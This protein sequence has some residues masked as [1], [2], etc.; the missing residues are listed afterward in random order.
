MSDQKIPVL[1]V[2]ATGMLG[3]AVHRQ[4]SKSDQIEL[5]LTVRDQ[6]QNVAVNFADDRNIC[7]FD[8]LEDD[9]NEMIEASKHDPMVGGYIVNCIGII[10]PHIA[11]NVG[12]A[13]YINSVLP[14]KLAELATAAQA[15]LIHISTDCVYSGQR[16]DYDELDSHDEQDVYGRSK[17]LGEPVNDAMVIRTSIIGPEVHNNS[18]LIAWVL[19]EAATG[20]KSIKGYTDHLWNGITTDTY[21]KIVRHIIEQ[22]LW[23][24]G[25]RHVHSPNRVNKYQLV[26][27]IAVA[28]NAADKLTVEPHVSGNYCDRTLSTNYPEFLQQ[29]N[30]PTIETQLSEYS[31]SNSN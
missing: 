6:S 31:S 22:D 11:K 7:V 16:G 23:V 5:S 25:L 28:F 15:R 24:K 27:Q 12:N 26:S 4:L 1:L 8:P 29:F 18:S 21:G 2:G 13:I 3:S 30:I 19:K 10:K 14:H 20:P 9:I 17:S